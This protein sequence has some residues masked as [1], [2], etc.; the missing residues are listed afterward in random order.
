MSWNELKPCLKVKKI[1]INEFIVRR[2]KIIDE[3]YSFRGVVHT[4]FV[5]LSL[6]AGGYTIAHVQILNT[7]STKKK[8]ALTEFSS[9]SSKMVFTVLWFQ[10]EH[11][12]NEASRRWQMFIC[13]NG[14]LWFQVA[15]VMSYFSLIYSYW[16]H[17]SD[18]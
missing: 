15:S 11:A 16:W 17:S 2:C 9:A 10:A 4:A 5:A 14:A 6:A 1:M 7:N 8:L 18:I 3:I 13:W 12:M